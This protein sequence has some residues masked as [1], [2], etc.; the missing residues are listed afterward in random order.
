MELNPLARLAQFGQSVWCD[1]IGRDLLLAGR[2]RTLIQEDGVSGVTSNPTIFYRA[3]T[4]ST[5]YDEAIRTLA[6]AGAGA[7]E[8][9]EA[10]MADDIR[11]AADELYPVHVATASKDGWVSIE[12]SPALAYDTQGTVSEAIRLRAFVGRP[13]VMVKVP[14]TAEG[15]GAVQDLAALGHSINVTLIFSLER[16]REVMESYLSG[17]ETLRARREA[18]ED[19]PDLR[20]VHGVASFFVS[21]IDTVVDRRL[22]ELIA[23][24]AA[25]G[26][27]G[28]G[29]EALRGKA[30]VASAKQAYRLFRET[31]SGPRWE[32]LREAGATLQ[33]PLWASTS[34]KDPAYSDI[35]YVQEL[36]GP[37]TV[38]TMPLN[39]LDAFRD[40]GRPAETL[41][42]GVQEAAAHLAALEAAGIAM[43]Q[44]AAGLERDG[45]RAFAESFEALQAALEVKRQESA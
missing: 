43:A 15:V 10:L 39:T 30:A 40:H 16:Y 5:A 22:G 29:L 21:R 32:A 25:A 2:L 35:L 12:V 27:G 36:I 23:G 24:R 28:A 8:I 44:I 4:E 26:K 3:I 6:S 9:M 19:V 33:R 13:N 14:A 42:Q 37:D 38:T 31:F 1:D 45:V 11:Y 20:E 18:G 7:L 41:T 17:L 34:T